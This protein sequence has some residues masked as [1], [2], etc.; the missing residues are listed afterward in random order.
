[1]VSERVKC[2]AYRQSYAQLYFWRTTQQQE[3]GLIEECDGGLQAFEFKWKP[4]K[5]RLPKPFAENYPGT[6][7]Q[8]ITTDNYTGFIY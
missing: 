5:A 2:N 4:R 8:T 6:E 7:L 1:M 3:I